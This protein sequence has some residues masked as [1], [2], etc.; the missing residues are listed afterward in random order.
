MIAGFDRVSHADRSLTHDLGPKAAPVDQ[1]ALHSCP[2]QLLEVRARF[3]KA[4]A[5]QGDASDLEF[6]ADQMVERNAAR[7]DV[8]AAVAR[9]EIDPVMALQGFKGL[10]FDEPQFAVGAG[11]VGISCN[12]V[13]RAIHLQ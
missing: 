3:A 7:D 8:A 6:A 12:L 13:K 2:R 10:D 9:L 4:D 5:A 11:P 1:S